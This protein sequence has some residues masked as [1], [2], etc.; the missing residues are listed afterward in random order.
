MPHIRDRSARAPWALVI[1]RAD[2]EQRELRAPLGASLPA[3]EGSKVKVPPVAR[4]EPNAPLL[5]R[6]VRHPFELLPGRFS[7]VELLVAEGRRENPA[8]R[9]PVLAYRAAQRED[10]SSKNPIMVFA[11]RP[12]ARPRPFARARENTIEEGDLE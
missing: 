10:C 5:M 9:E 7:R 11:H 4:T 2:E 6:I 8:A 12:E 3:R 1:E